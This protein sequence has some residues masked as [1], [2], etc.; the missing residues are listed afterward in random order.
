VAEHHIPEA[1]RA[2]G[3][4]F[5][6]ELERLAALNVPWACAILSYQALLLKEDRSRDIERAVSLCRQ[7]AQAGDAYAQYML[8]WA[9][10]LKGDL[11]GAYENMR[12]SARKL[13]PPAVLDIA[14]F[15]SPNW[16]A[17]RTIRERNLQL[18]ISNRVGHVG[19]LARRLQFYRTG[20]FGALNQMLGY[21]LVPYAFLKVIIPASFAPFS[22]AAF[23]FAPGLSTK[24]IRFELSSQ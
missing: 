10:R 14:N 21:L 4:T 5:L 18:T 19:T 3:S 22:A 1:K 8:S 16:G 9:L 12:K 15:R 2:L 7:P 6:S 17:A 23:F 24:A 11:D 13:F 20:E